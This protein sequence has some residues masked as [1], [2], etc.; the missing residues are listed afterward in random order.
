MED[1]AERTERLER[2]EGRLERERRAR[3]EAELIAERATRELYETAQVATRAR[4]IAELFGTI[5]VAANE[6]D[7]VE[8]ALQVAVDRICD[9]TGWPVG[10]ALVVDVSKPDT[11]VSARIWHLDDAARVAAFKELT[12]RTRFE[13]G[14]GLPGRVLASAAPAWI[15]S[16]TQDPNFPRRPAAEVAGLGAGFALPVMVR[17]D[18]RAVLEFFSNEELRIDAELLRAMGMIGHQVGRVLEREEAEHRLTRQALYDGLTGLPNRTLLT[19][20][21]DHA[22]AR[23]ARAKTTIDM[24]FFDVDDFKTINDSLGHEAG[25]QVLAVVAARVQGC[26]RRSDTLARPAAVTVARL[27]GDEFAVLLE[28]CADLAVVAERIGKVLREPIVILGREL[29]LSVS[30]GGARGASFAMAD[31]LLRAANL[32]MHAAK[33]NG[34]DRFEAYAAEMQAEVDRRLQLASELRRAIDQDQLVLHFQPEVRLD[35]L[36]VVGAE[37]LVRWQHP[38]HGLVAPAEFIPLAEESGLIVPMG[39]WVLEEA[40]RAAA[41]WE[42]D[43]LLSSA[44]VA[45]NLSGRQLREPNLAQVVAAVLA[46][47]GLPASRLCLEVTESVLLE[48]GE[49]AAIALLH[50]LREVGVTL[51]VDD[52]GTGYSSLSILRRLPV[53]VL[54]IDRSF[55]SELPGDEDAGTIVW[56]VVRLGHNLGLRV[57][58]EGIETDAQLAALRHFD[59]DEGQGYLFSRP[60]PATELPDAVRGLA[61]A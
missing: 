27:G 53:Q 40:C 56:A 29:F 22:M 2:L 36:A 49:D 4:E 8:D 38:V 51:A 19:E 1:E 32:A 42:K 37:A 12:E 9:F 54:K 44:L 59:C 14:V 11:M 16:V 50:Q 3:H 15:T 21:L 60:V 10:H 39:R 31:E 55:V 43:A 47:T 30:I 35:D 45:V 46:A 48:E 20:R 23:Q 33:R 41:S 34:K 58:A 24:L 6:A 13:R 17:S 18:V 7:R 52:F 5:A 28:D 57:L 61:P 25:D 26:L